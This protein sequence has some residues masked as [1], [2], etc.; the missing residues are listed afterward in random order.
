MH[1]CQKQKNRDLAKVKKENPI[2]QKPERRAGGVEGVNT[3][4][5]RDVH[6]FG[7]I[8]DSWAVVNLWEETFRN[9]GGRTF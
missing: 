4:V 3:L 9:M 5:Q 2:E 6:V 8:K 7:V 1:V